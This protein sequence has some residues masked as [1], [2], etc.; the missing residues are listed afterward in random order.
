MS[1]ALRGA[2]RSMAG[3]LTAL[4]FA[5][6]LIVGATN[7]LVGFAVFRLAMATLPPWSFRTGV[8]Q[9]LCYFVGS[10][11]SF[12]W[13][14]LWTFKSKGPAAREGVRFFAV[15]GGLM[16]FTSFYMWVAVDLMKGPEN[17]N[18]VGIVGVAT[19]LNYFLLKFY[20]FRVKRG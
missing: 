2:A 16:A 14:R 9:F 6:F 17:L 18:W 3:R 4:P 13:N 20:A 1:D 19:L 7:T 11:W 8:S 10:I 15:Q 12:V 5:R